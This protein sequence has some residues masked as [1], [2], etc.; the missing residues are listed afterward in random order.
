MLHPLA[1]AAGEPRAPEDEDPSMSQK[2][3]REKLPAETGGEDSA[4]NPQSADDEMAARAAQE[5]AGPTAEGEGPGDEPADAPDR[6]IAPDAEVAR[7][8]PAEGHEHPA[9]DLS[10]AAVCPVSD[11]EAEA[12]VEAVIF[13]SDKPLTVG[14]LADIAQ[15]GGARV[16][17]QA[18]DRLNARYEQMAC[19]FR[20]MHIAGGFQM[21]TL[22]EYGQVLARLNKTREEGRLSQAAMEA[23]AIIAYRQPILRA[24]IEAIRGVACGEVLRGLM[25][26]NLVRIVGRAEEI[27][28]P[29]LYGTSKHFLEVF[30][31]AALDDLPNAEQLRKPSHKAAEGSTSPEKLGDSGPAQPLAA[32]AAI[33]EGGP[34]KPFDTAQG[35]PAENAAVEPASPS[36]E[37]AS[38]PAPEAVADTAPDARP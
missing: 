37:T 2:K 35:K 22:P 10:D 17:R 27:G 3:K 21:Q 33:A 6:L 31:L 16:V 24:D 12:T 9:D 23:V 20:V 28:R 11:A 18:I 30:G 26:R 29:L 34:D 25:E 8:E 32:A 7:D 15:I 14:K 19:A 4:A 1:S 5:N 38:P 36:P 13:A